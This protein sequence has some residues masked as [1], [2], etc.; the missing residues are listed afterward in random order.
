MI[1]FKGVIS[2]KYKAWHCDEIAQSTGSKCKQKPK[3]T[4]SET[5]TTR[6]SGTKLLLARRRYDKLKSYG[7]P[8]HGCVDGFSCIFLY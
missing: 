2:S 7:L 6:I 5:K 4:S 3:S 8:K 1:A